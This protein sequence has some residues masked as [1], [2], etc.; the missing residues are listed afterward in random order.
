M[1]CV[2]FF[3][4]IFYPKNP[5][6]L[7]YLVTHSGQNP[8]KKAG[9]KLCIS[10]IATL[11]ERL[12]RSSRLRSYLQLS[13]GFFQIHVSR[14]SSELQG[15][16]IPRGQCSMNLSLYHPGVLRTRGSRILKRTNE[17]LIRIFGAYWFST[18]LII[19]KE[20]VKLINYWP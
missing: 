11:C 2:T 8:V 16:D 19:S 10:I 3:S 4:G 18:D 13:L 1:V 15:E 5:E 12:S 17:M 14:V 7:L 9:K 20:K 6:Y